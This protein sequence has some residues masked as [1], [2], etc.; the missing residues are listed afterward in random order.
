[1]P[2]QYASPVKHSRYLGLLG[3]EINILERHDMRRYEAKL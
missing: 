3:Y 2:R 1:M